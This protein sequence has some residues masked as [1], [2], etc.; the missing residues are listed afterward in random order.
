LFFNY[1]KAAISVDSQAIAKQHDNGL[2]IKEAIRRSRIQ[3][4]TTVTASAD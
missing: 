2:A 1:L 3:A 4:I